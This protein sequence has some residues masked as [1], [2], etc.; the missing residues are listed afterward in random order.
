MT[1]DDAHLRTQLRALAH[2]EPTPAF[3]PTF[4]S[5]IRAGARRRRTRGRLATALAVVLVG[6]AIP[7]S[8]LAVTRTGQPDHAIAAGPAGATP[9]SASTPTSRPAQ[10]PV[11][12][13]VPGAAGQPPI[14]IRLVDTPR[15]V[16]L[17]ESEK[18]TLIRTCAWSVNIPGDTGR[19]LGAIHDKQGYA[20]IIVS[21]T[22]MA[23]CDIPT[24]KDGGPAVDRV[25]GSEGNGAP[26]Y[27]EY[28]LPPNG[29]LK[30]FNYQGSGWLY[31]RFGAG[32]VSPDVA[33]VLAVFPTGESI[34]V[35]ILDGGGFLA[36]FK[37]EGTN[38]PAIDQ[39]LAFYA[40][41]GAGKLLDRL[42]AWKISNYG[43]GYPT[44]QRFIEMS[45]ACIDAAV[46]APNSP[47]GVPADA[48]ATYNGLAIPGVAPGRDGIVKTDVGKVRI[49]CVGP[50]DES[51]WPIPS[52]LTFRGSQ[53]L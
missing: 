39:P 10:P 2:D 48:V 49:S 9:T 38:F 36:R 42:D 29:P 45:Q 53:P 27:N 21:E 28:L 22:E 41:D 23:Y 7:L 50:V 46:Q 8:L 44:S 35:P 4:P 26:Y 40:F 19:V 14:K 3:G 5:T 1:L 33:M 11:P 17:T 30:S 12:P 6:V 18:A 20:A 37:V 24:G 15:A 13:E 47:A 34:V 51:G 43:S 32:R 25:E 31:A 16:P 52:K